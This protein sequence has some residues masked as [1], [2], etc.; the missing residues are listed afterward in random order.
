[1]FSFQR[2]FIFIYDSALNGYLALI[3]QSPAAA[4]SVKLIEIYKWITRWTSYLNGT[5]INSLWK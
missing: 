1:M 2:Y 3:F 4:F 5:Q